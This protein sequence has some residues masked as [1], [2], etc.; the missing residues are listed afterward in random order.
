[1]WMISGGLPTNFIPVDD[2]RKYCMNILFSNYKIEGPEKDNLV[3]RTFTLAWT[4]TQDLYPS[5]GKGPGNE[6]VRRILFILQS[7]L[8]NPCQGSCILL[9]QSRSPCAFSN[10]LG[11]GL[12]YSRPAG[13]DRSQIRA[14]FVWK[15]FENYNALLID[16]DR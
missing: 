1:M 7:S 3:P 11:N 4:F 12:F 6:V 16:E 9:R 13:L 10:S 8:E 15:L 2:M 5:Q 14:W